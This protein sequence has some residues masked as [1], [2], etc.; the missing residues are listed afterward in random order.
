MLT[1]GK[2]TSETPQ[3]VFK[4]RVEQRQDE[5]WKSLFDGAIQ[6]A[7]PIVELIGMDRN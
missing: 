7:A 4:G 3:D 1:D 2:N 5:G 6:D